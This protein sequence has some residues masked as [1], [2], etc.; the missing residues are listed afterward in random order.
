MSFITA[1]IRHFQLE[2][3]ENK[4]TGI[5]T[6][7][8]I[9]VDNFVYDLESFWESNKITQNVFNLHGKNYVEFYNFFIPDMYFC[10]GQL[11]SFDEEDR[12]TPKP[13]VLRILNGIKEN[14]W[15]ADY[16]KPKKALLNY[17][18]LK[19][20]KYTL[21]PKQKEAV[22]AYNDKVLALN[23]N[24]YL[25]AADVGT[26]K[27]IMGLAIYAGLEA[28]VLII[29]CPKYIIDSVWVD[30]LDVQFG[31]GKKKIWQSNLNMP[32]KRG[33]D[34]YIMHYEYVG[35]SLGFFENFRMRKPCIILDESHNLNNV[36]ADRT[37]EYLKLCKVTK[38]NNIIH[39]SGTPIKAIGWE[40]IPLL[41][42]IDPLFTPE[43]EIRFKQIYGKS[44]T[45]ALEILKNRIGLVSFKI[46]FKEVMGDALPIEKTILIKVPNSERFTLPFIREELKVFVIEKTK[47]YTKEMSGH[48]AVFLEAVK[49][50]GRT[51]RTDEEEK[52]LEQ[53][54]EYIK[55]IKRG[56]DARTMGHISKFCNAFEKEKIM[57]VLDSNMKKKFKSS[58]SIYKYMNLKIMGEFLGQVLG[59][60]RIELHTAMIK[61]AG[62]DKI[63]NA[64][65]KKT[66]IFTDYV[67]T[68][69]EAVKY[70]TKKGFK[71]LIVFSDTN[72]YVAKI[73]ETFKKSDIENPLIAT[74]KS[75]SVGVT[76]T[77]ASTIIL[78]NLP[79]RSDTY[80]Q[81]IARAFRLGQTSQV[82]VYIL[83][84]DTGDVPNISTRMNDILDWSRNQVELIVGTENVTVEE[85]DRVLRHA[86]FNNM[87]MFEQGLDIIK[88]KLELNSRFF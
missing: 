47:Q 56:F 38:C 17:S 69:K 22:E 51:I 37:R 68:A 46:P 55:Q 11:L 64:S 30:A 20:L 71:P 58:K 19:T 4:N 79:F 72:K 21:L 36:E 15:Y 25:L 77:V 3:T 28:D 85:L 44:A 50:Y 33:Y 63:V 5:I 74:Y 29:V 14:T 1:I 80:K 34:A 35:N 81:S 61:T 41:R 39:E 53:Y 84:L 23:L 57:P 60:K 86:L 18:K 62:L 88:Q 13:D 67:D 75:L 16:Y 8:N 32:L 6:I 31:K 12:K 7:R 54:I 43:V 40:I 59:R 65:E 73:I 52:N 42:A 10:V 82:Y 27:S 26:G 78:I 83:L 45:R 49:L 24:G 48:E 9:D 70:F 87:N 76:L 66:V 2:V